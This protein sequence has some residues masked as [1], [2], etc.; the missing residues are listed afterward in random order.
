M[1][2]AAHDADTHDICQTARAMAIKIIPL[3]EE[4]AANYVS[5]ILYPIMQL[6]NSSGRSLGATGSTIHRMWVDISSPQ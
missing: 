1:L 3:M 4:I 5:P 6:A 2:Y